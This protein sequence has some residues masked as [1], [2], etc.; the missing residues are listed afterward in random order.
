[1][2]DAGRG[3]SDSL[4][5]SEREELA[6]LRRENK[7]LRLERELLKEATAFFAR[8][9]VRFAFINAEKAS[10]PVA[11]MCR[12]LGVSRA[13]FYAWQSRSPSPRASEDR[14]LAVEVAAI[15]SAS[16][17]RYGSLRVHE[18]LRGQGVRIGRKR[19]ARLM[20]EQGLCARRKRHF[21]AT[22]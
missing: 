1:E 16:R 6:Q 7:R 22:T 11:L 17:R 10:L 15:H 20:R 19:V 12:V 8:E 21:K 13:G 18:E 2:I 14:R 3:S 9:R 4:T 5:T